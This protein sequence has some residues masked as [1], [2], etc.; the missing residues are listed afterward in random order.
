MLDV[1]WN[2]SFVF[3]MSDSDGNA[4]MEVVGSCLTAGIIL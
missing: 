4:S 2:M 3:E 1:Y